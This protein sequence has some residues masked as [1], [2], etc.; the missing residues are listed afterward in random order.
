[1]KQFTLRE[2]GPQDIEGVFS[3]LGET[4]LL[5]MIA[6]PEIYQA[7]KNIKPILDYLKESVFD[8]NA[9]IF[10][11]EEGDEIL[12]AIHCRIQSSSENPVLTPRKFALI[13]NIAV[14]SAHRRRGIGEALMKR[15]EQWAKALGAS[16]IELTVW[17]FNQTA[18]DFYRQLDYQPIHQR[19]SKE[20]K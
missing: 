20:L 11:A 3:V 1:M 6:H 18:K 10:L 19:M 14:A 7:P 16:S 12:A 15:A 8:P 17:D 2:A 13:E 4:Q 5:H 9:V